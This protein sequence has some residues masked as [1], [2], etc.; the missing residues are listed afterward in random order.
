MISLT[1]TK[2]G[3]KLGCRRSQFSVVISS[4]APQAINL[5]PL[6]FNTSVLSTQS[7]VLCFLPDGT[8]CDC[9][10]DVHAI[11]FDFGNNWAE[12]VGQSAYYALQTNR[13]A[14]IVLVLWYWK[15]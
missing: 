2:G 6:P 1:Q 10:T 7:S 3:S 5:S 14:G 15:H 8:R 13:K 11:E 12:A 9:L 4:R